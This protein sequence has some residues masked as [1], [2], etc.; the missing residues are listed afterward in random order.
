MPLPELLDPEGK[1]VTAGLRN[2]GLAEIDNVRVG[3]HIQAEVEAPSKDK[4]KELVTQA[5][6]EL[7][8]NPVI[9]DYDFHLEKVSSAS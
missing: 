3:K 8:S 2:L 1:A 6:D 9:E 5:C 4:A 7:L